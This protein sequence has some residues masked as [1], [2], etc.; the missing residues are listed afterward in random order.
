MKNAHPNRM[1][2]IGSGAVGPTVNNGE[3]EYHNFRRGI[4][5]YILNAVQ[6]WSKL[7]GS[8]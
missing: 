7:D 4:Y 8:G 1:S 2:K 3:T 5:I 6:P